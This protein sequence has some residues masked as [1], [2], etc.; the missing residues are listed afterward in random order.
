MCFSVLCIYIHLYLNHVF[1]IFIY[2]LLFLS[3]FTKHICI[4]SF[5]LEFS[6]E[7]DI[8]PVGNQIN[9]KVNDYLGVKLIFI[10]NISI[11]YQLTNYLSLYIL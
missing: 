10:L 6:Q 11:E 8:F 9:W 2:L 3:L 5:L 1:R 7:K 4:V